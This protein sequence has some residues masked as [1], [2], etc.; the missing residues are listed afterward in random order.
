VPNLNMGKTLVSALTSVLNQLDSDYEVVVVDDGSKDDSL[1]K[2]MQLEQS[3]PNMRT[4]FLEKDASR[5]LAETRNISVR[6]AR[7]EYCLLHIDCD[8]IWEPYIL[9]FVK[10]FHRIEEFLDEDILLSGHQINMAR[11]EFLLK[12]GPYKQWHFGEDRDMWYRL[13]L[14]GK[15]IPI[16]HVVFRHRMPLT[17]KQKLTK[18]YIE[19]GKNLSEEIRSGRNLAY[20]IRNLWRDYSNHSLKFRFYKVMVFPLAFARAKRLGP[21]ESTDLL[22]RWNEIKQGAKEQNGTVFE[23]FSKRGST[24]DSN[25]L[26]PQGKW[27]FGHKAAEKSISDMPQNL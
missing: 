8:D 3:F 23:I 22:T 1:E 7:G 26:S 19:T 10:V 13:G 11:R 12:H 17:T 2:L 6:E 4:I 15:Y 20:Y 21:T 24:F 18:K 16:D 27:I 5:A 14:L 9:E 25:I